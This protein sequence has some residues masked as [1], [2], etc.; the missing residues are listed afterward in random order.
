M[1][2]RLIDLLPGLAAINRNR[3]RRSLDDVAGLVH[4]SPGRTQRVFT[5][6]I[7]ESPGRYQRR[8]ALDRAAAQ[9][10]TTDR[11]VAAIAT[12][13][14]FGSHE[15]FTRAFNE[16]FGCPPRAYRDRADDGWNPV[17]SARVAQTSPCIGL[18]HR[19]TLPQ[20]TV[21]QRTSRNQE[22]VMET[23]AQPV[24]VEDLSPT[25]ML[26][27]ARRIDKDEFAAVLAEL[28]P[29]VFQYVME[30]GLAM[31]GPPFVR[32]LEQSA[33]FLSVQAG[34]PLIEQP[35]PPA[36]DRNI[37]VGELPG[38][39]TAAT[40]HR[41]PYD[42]LGDSHMVLD[43]WMTANERRPSGPPWEVYLTDPGDVPDPSD[44]ETQIL[45]PLEPVD[46]SETTEL[47]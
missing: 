24:T 29:A 16:A 47:G 18:Y 27:M 38:G 17:V 39:P 34:I 33:A 23:N 35:K 12:D 32:Y 36:A 41:G 11:P 31:A 28:L 5:R 20:P 8:V 40:I 37:E 43:R 1:G 22:D 44:W 46:V 19:S 15:G 42:T 45:W 3:R 30:E 14:G 26:Y 4:L 9:L 7:G 2:T 6:L 25:P 10:A 13:N 21:D